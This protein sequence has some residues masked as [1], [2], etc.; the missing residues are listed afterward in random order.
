LTALHLPTD[1]GGLFI[2]KESMHQISGRAYVLAVCR[3]TGEGIPVLTVLS[4]SFPGPTRNHGLT[5][6][7]YSPLLFLKQSIIFLSASAS[8]CQ[9][10]TLISE[11]PIEASF[12]TFDELLFGAKLV[13]LL[14]KLL[15]D[16]EVRHLV[17]EAIRFL[18]C[19]P[20]PIDNKQLR[21]VCLVHGQFVKITGFTK[22]TALN[23]ECLMLTQ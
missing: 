13:E 12:T 7:A 6:S 11:C 5:N 20:I 2:E 17:V 21:G 19:M 1:L 4:T 18:H 23:V 8:L 22:N 9:Q 3:C 14:A 16:L 10:R 15:R